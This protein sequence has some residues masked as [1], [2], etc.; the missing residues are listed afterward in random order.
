MV[1]F[2]VGVSSEKDLEKLIEA[3]RKSGIYLSVLGFGMGNYQDSKIRNPG[4]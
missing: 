1:T 4:R 2:N 3:K